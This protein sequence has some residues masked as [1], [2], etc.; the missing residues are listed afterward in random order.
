MFFAHQRQFSHSACIMNAVF[1]Y[2]S[3]HSATYLQWYAFNKKSTLP[4]MDIFFNS[5]N[6]WSRH[7]LLTAFQRWL[8]MSFSPA[9]SN[10]MCYTV[11]NEALLHLA[12][13][14]LPN[15]AEAMRRLIIILQ[16]F[17]LWGTW[18]ATAMN[19]TC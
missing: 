13:I 1:T 10:R 18:C 3:L 5:T 8:Q 19:Q 9:H 15:L 16:C 14:L 6:S 12:H 11:P 4:F 2:S 17:T 7:T